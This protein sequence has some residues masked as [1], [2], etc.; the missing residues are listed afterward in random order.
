LAQQDLDPEDIDDLEEYEE[1]RKKRSGFEVVDVGKLLVP[2]VWAGEELEVMS[3]TSVKTVDAEDVSD[4]A[5][6]DSMATV[7][8]AMPSALAR[9]PRPISGKFATTLADTHRP[10]LMKVTP[11][12]MSSGTT[13]AK[14]EG[15]RLDIIYLNPRR[16]MFGLD[17]PP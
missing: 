15:S 5:S 17:S 8:A 13:W 3:P 2:K 12:Q 14:L 11:P 9:T 6:D 10:T 16:P 7:T 1:T 4:Q